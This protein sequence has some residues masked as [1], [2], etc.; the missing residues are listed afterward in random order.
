MITKTAVHLAANSD[1]NAK[2][3]NSEQL[4]ARPLLLDHGI[5]YKCLLVGE[6][7]KVACQN[8]RVPAAIYPSAALPTSFSTFP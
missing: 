5:T 1:I 8:L 7:D 3:S 4:T 6:K 2:T